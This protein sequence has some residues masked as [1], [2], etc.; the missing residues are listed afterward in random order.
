V[1]M[2]EPP[3]SWE[4]VMNRVAELLATSADNLPTQFPGL[5]SEGTRQAW[6]DIYGALSGKGY[7]QAHILAADQ[8]RHW[9]LARGAVLAVMAC[10]ALKNYD[11][12]S[13]KFFDPIGENREKIAFMA[14]TIDGQPIA[15]GAGESGVG[16]VSHGMVRAAVETGEEFDRMGGRG[17]RRYY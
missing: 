15:P 3:V 2:P 13:I 9:C 11:L 1:P 8:L 14:I 17:R 4:A 5:C 12:E 7:S 6:I 10:S 16:G